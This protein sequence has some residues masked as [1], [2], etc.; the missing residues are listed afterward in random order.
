[1]MVG[2]AVAERPVKG[3]TKRTK[4]E[5]KRLPGA[6]KREKAIDEALARGG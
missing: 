6:E 1:M 2:E 5:E 4:K 3:Q